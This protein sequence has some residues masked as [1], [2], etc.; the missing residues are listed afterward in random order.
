MYVVCMRFKLEAFVYFCEKRGKKQ[1]PDH[2]YDN[3]VSVDTCIVLY[4]YM[5]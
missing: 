2:L 1:I 5:S 4:I 3:S